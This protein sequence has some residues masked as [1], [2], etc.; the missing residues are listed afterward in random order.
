MEQRF[1]LLM[2]MPGMSG[3]ELAARA[4]EKRP[5][6]LVLLASG[7]SSEIAGGT[8]CAFQTLAKPYGARTLGAASAAARAEMSR[9]A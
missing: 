5:D 7:C 9:E 6:L 4:R 3:R 2:L 8:A 1:Q